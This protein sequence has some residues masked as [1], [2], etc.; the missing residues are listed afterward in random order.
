[1]KKLFILILIISAIVNLFIGFEHLF[2]LEMEKASL[3]FNWFVTS[4]L[5]ALVFKYKL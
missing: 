2:C 4:T 3:D 5:A 1:M